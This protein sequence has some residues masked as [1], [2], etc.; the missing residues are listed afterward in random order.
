MYFQRVTSKG[1]K[2]PIAP[3]LVLEHFFGIRFI[4]GENAQPYHLRVGPD[5]EGEDSCCQGTEELR[6]VPHW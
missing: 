1:Y 6:T 4:S 2:F 5:V 3:S